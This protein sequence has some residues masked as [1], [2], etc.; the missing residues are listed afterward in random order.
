MR[1]AQFR[2]HAHATVHAGVNGAGRRNPEMIVRR[3]QRPVE[4]RIEGIRLQGWRRPAE[5]EK[6][7][8]VRREEASVGRADRQCESAIIADMSSLH[9]RADHVCSMLTSHS[10]SPCWPLCSGSMSGTQL[11]ANVASA[12]SSEN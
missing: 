4:Q 9:A 12:H 3:R 1:Q 7:V 11:F 5:L 8:A 10:M 2:A 6:A